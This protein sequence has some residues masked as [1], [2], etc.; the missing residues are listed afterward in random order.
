MPRRLVK[1]ELEILTG[2][3]ELEQRRELDY[4]L[5]TKSNFYNVEILNYDSKDLDPQGKP[6]LKG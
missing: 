5:R 1:M 2:A 4:L 6:I 3:S